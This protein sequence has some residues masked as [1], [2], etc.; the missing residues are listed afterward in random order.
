LISLT[1]CFIV[2]L[3][4]TPC[5]HSGGHHVVTIISVSAFESNMVA[6]STKTTNGRLT[7]RTVDGATPQ[8]ERYV[9]WDSELKGFGLR[10]EPS[11]AKTFLVR[12][13]PKGAGRTGT[14]RFLKVGRYGMVSPEEARNQAKAILG[15]VAAGGDPAGAAREAITM[16]ALA[17]RYLDEEVTPKLKPGTAKLYSHY[18]RGLAIPEIGRLKADAITRSEISKLHLKIGRT[19]PVAANRLLATLSALFA[20]GAKQSMLPDGFNP[21]RGIEKF[22]EAARERFL[23]QAELERLGAAINEAETKG[24]PWR[25]DNEKP[26]AKHIPKTERITRLSPFAAA[27]IRLLLFTGCRLREILD[28]RWSDLDLERGMFNLADSKTGRKSVI[29]NAPALAVIETLPRM[30]DYVIQGEQAD[31]PRADL[32]RP[33]A[34][35]CRRAGLERVRIHDLRHSFASIGVSAGHGLPIVGEL[36]GHADASSTARYAHLDADPVRRVSNSIAAA[37]EAAMTGKNCEVAS[38]KIPLK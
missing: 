14:K 37:I 4:T 19:R 11:G 25:I 16:A 21:A 13:R 26:T 36:L 34:I 6:P 32:K 28:L 31:K 20:Y 12:Y 30:G 23:T 29:L 38:T 5:F 7:K 22:R 17:E 24:V 2:V 15:A 8:S 10:V 35:V 9:V 1:F 3:A 33:W 18:L 27:A